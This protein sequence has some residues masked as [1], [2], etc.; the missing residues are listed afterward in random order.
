MRH[1]CAF[2]AHEICFLN[3]AYIFPR[4]YR[5][6]AI[7]GSRDVLL[8]MSG[9]WNTY[10]DFDFLLGVMANVFAGGFHSSPTPTQTR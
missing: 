4:K 2:S 9:A 7:A 1:R 8:L 10:V 5:T 3:G 6:E